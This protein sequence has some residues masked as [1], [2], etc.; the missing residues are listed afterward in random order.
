MPPPHCTDPQP[1]E[2]GSWVHT[3]SIPWEAVWDPGERLRDRQQRSRGERGGKKQCRGGRAGGEMLV[4]WL[5]TH[6][7]QAKHSGGLYHQLYAHKFYSSFPLHSLR[8]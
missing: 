4:C 1:A 5:L 8:V 3:A 6:K 7:G 2:D